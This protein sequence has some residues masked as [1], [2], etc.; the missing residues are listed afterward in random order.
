MFLEAI[1]ELHTFLKRVL[2]H[3]K[4]ELVSLKSC[5]STTVPQGQEQASGNFFKQLRHWR[6]HTTGLRGHGGTLFHLIS[7]AERHS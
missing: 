1:L 4:L 5:I 6:K 3:Y 2:V 7:S